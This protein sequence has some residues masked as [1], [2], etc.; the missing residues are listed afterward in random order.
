MRISRIEVKALFGQYDYDIPLHLTDR[1]TFIYGENGCGKTTVLKMI[2][3]FFALKF[4]QLSRVP[5]GRLAVLMDD[6]SR[7]VVTRKAADAP[8][9]GNDGGRSALEI[10]YF[11]LGDEV[12]NVK[13][14]GIPAGSREH[15]LLA[16]ELARENHRLLRTGFQ[17]WLD[18]ETDETIDVA[19]VLARYGSQVPSLW[20]PT[21]K[22]APRAVE[23]SE[24]KEFLHSVPC[25]LIQTQRLM[26]DVPNRQRALERGPD[27]RVN[28]EFAVD[29]DATELRS[30][31]QETLAAYASTSQE[32][33]RSF[34]AR[35]LA[36][37]TGRAPAKKTL[38]SQLAQLESQ[39]VRL[40]R[41]GLLDESG[42]DEP[43]KLL[44]K[45]MTDQ[46]RRVLSIYIEDTNQKLKVLQEMAER[47]DL[48]AGSINARFKGKQIRISKDRGFSVVNERQEV[49]SP[50]QLSSG[51]QHEVVLFY[52]LL[53]KVQP[54]T[55]VMIDEP[56]LSL[57]VD[58]QN[59]FIGDISKVAHM[60]QLDVLAATHS[61]DIIGDRWDLAV[62]LVETD[63][64]GIPN[65][66]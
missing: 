34:P 58:W 36:A 66:N 38:E 52:E 56:E 26:A 40:M 25:K 53:F 57:H 50:S 28:Q 45:G 11:K 64:A 60:Q 48:F 33:D 12:L 16:E 21:D 61:P 46:Q 37:S 13:M 15:V 51:E 10:Q 55:L 19:E 65:R 62:R 6:D 20:K 44:G 8:R 54:D 39:R 5:F 41:N 9:R 14:T 43:G 17:Q 3:D 1:I 22:S 63:D 32:L 35:L 30:S 29:T 42:V 2:S 59:R 4:G 31:I 24:L 49:L 27:D 7:F 23:L 18:R 47:L